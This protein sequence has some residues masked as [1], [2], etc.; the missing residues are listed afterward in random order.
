MP[1]SGPLGSVRGAVSNAR[2]Y[3]ERYSLD[4]L[5]VITKGQRETGGQGLFQAT[6]NLN[7]TT[8]NPPCDV[9]TS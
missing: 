1:E 8:A 5:G 4:T 9:S 7:P 2:P 6:D 3:R